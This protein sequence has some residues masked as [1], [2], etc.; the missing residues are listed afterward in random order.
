MR[1]SYKR[2]EF[3]CKYLKIKI[4]LQKY[5]EQISYSLWYVSTPISLLLKYATTKMY[6][7][8]WNLPQ[9]PSVS[10]NIFPHS[11]PRIPKLIGKKMPYLCGLTANKYV[12]LYCSDAVQQLWLNHKR[13]PGGYHLS[14]LPLPHFQSIQ[15]SQ[16]DC[17]HSHA[18]LQ[19]TPSSCLL[20]RKLLCLTI[21]EPL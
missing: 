21:Q 4:P 14:T 11:L 16:A 20:L 7:E 1:M 10:R 19:K 17:I 15:I 2:E 6:Y 9:Q 13:S 8:N 12:N 5:M 18:F 3:W